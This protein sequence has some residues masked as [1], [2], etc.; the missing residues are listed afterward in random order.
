M[1]VRG[2]E[3]CKP[4]GFKS[5]MGLVAREPWDQQTDLGTRTASSPGTNQ[6]GSLPHVQAARSPMLPTTW[7]ISSFSSLALAC[8]HGF[9]SP[10][11]RFISSQ[12]TLHSENFCPIA[13]SSPRPWEQ[14]AAG[15]GDPAALHS[16]L[17]LTEETPLVFLST[18]PPRPGWSDVPCLPFLAALGM[19]YGGVVACFDSAGFTSESILGRNVILTQEMGNQDQVTTEQ[20]EA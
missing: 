7:T 11:W 3:L 20:S 19:S 12:R 4:Q 9:L 18:V 14:L 6:A 1:G 16:L 2:S 10:L 15:V 17:G 8:Q 13:G 5:L